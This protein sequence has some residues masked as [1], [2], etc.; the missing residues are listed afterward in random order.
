MINSPDYYVATGHVNRES[1][2]IPSEP[3]IREEE[4]VPDDYL[5]ME[6]A[7]NRK[8]SL[9][10]LCSHS[11]IPQQQWQQQKRSSLNL[12]LRPSNNPASPPLLISPL[13]SNSHSSGKKDETE[14]PYLSMS[15]SMEWIEST[16]KSKRCDKSLNNINPV[17]LSAKEDDCSYVP[18]APLSQQASSEL[19][20]AK[21]ST[22]ASNNS[23]I[24]ITTTTAT[25]GVTTNLTPTNKSSIS[26][27]PATF[28]NSA[29]E[30]LSEKDLS[31]KQNQT[32]V[33]QNGLILVDKTAIKNKARKNKF[34]KKFSKV[35]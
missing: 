15:P 18:M 12:K 34:Q 29:S 3:P 4:V 27:T 16:E 32:Q 19:S 22:Q 10:S 20:L 14:A 30:S 33:K 7:P 31:S 8:T 21:L 2:A 24:T 17:T 13:L 26:S 1:A 35:T 6:F 28:I 25:T 5:L 9:A 23:T 11:S